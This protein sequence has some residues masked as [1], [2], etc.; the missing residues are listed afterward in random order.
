VK[1]PDEKIEEIRGASDIVEIVSTYVRLKRRGKSYVGLCPFHQE[2]TPSFHVTPDKQMFYCFG[3]SEG[4]NVF[5]FI[6]RIEKVS[7][8]EAVRSL[9]QRAG[10]NLPE[11]GSENTESSQ[12]EQIYRANMLAARFFH[13][14]M[15]H[16]PEGEYALN[17][18]RERG[19]GNETIRQFGLGYAPRGWQVLIDHVR[20]QGVTPEQLAVAGLATRRD[21]GGYYDRFR[22]RAMFPIFSTSGRVAAFAGRQLYDDDTIA[23]YIN[24]AETPVYQKSRILYGLSLTRDAIRKREYALLVEGY[25]DLI[26]VYQAGVHNVVASSGTA[27]TDEQIRLLG[28]YAPAVVIV[29]DADSAGS[30]AALRSVDLILERGLDVRIAQLPA[31]EDPDSF[32]RR[33]GAE[34]FMDAVDTSVSFIDFKAESLRGEGMFDSPERQAQAVRALMETLACI[35][36][37]LKRNF[38]IKALAERYGIYEST[39]HRELETL[40]R[41]KRRPSPSGQTERSAPRHEPVHQSG[42]EIHDGT[43][44]HS[45]SAAYGAV[46]RDILKLILESER[47]VL[48]FIFSQVREDE[49]NHPVVRQ[50][51]AKLL[52]RYRTAGGIDA[53]Q[54]LN[55]SAFSE[56]TAIITRLLAEKYEVS[57]RWERIRGYEEFSVNMQLSIDVVRSL[58]KLNV[59]SRIDAIRKHIREAERNGEDSLSLTRDLQILQQELKLIDKQYSTMIRRPM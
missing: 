59:R 32:V 54:C 57:E 44:E 23:K 31:G 20:D 29:Y 28:R 43:A 35:P 33:H 34:A 55:S 45:V 41:R 56:F 12:N 46:E 3:C 51:Y 42:V 5:T 9:A 15:M 13:H 10:I 39:L 24:T 27:L 53:N 40:M 16:T 6:M 30:A 47:D 22:G 19:F 25:T 36:D 21:D 18:F 26:S 2:K 4:G 14:S 8:I 17:Y 49:L 50:L 38:Y 37:E 52:E 48:E 7:F 1:I 11:T 58:K